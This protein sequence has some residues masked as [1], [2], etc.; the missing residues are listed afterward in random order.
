MSV[1]TVAEQRVAEQQAAVVGAMQFIFS[2]CSVF[3]EEEYHATC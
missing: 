1:S 3:V 2:T